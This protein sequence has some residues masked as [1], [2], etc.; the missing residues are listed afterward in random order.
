ML[1]ALSEGVDQVIDPA[2]K[3]DLA[4]AAGVALTSDQVMKLS[5]AKCSDPRS[6]LKIGCLNVHFYS[7]V[8]S[9]LLMQQIITQEINGL[10]SCAKYFNKFSGLERGP[11]RLRLWQAL[12]APFERRLCWLPK[13]LGPYSL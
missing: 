7:P 12:R 8:N 2:E 3:V 6:W 13:W 4:L 10:K 5:V 11:G 1:G 9:L